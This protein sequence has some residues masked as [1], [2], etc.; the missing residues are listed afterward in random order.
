MGWKQRCLSRLL[1]PHVGLRR[2][3]ARSS[4]R[5]RFGF[6]RSRTAP[7]G[8]AFGLRTTES[9]AW[10]GGVRTSLRLSHVGRRRL[11]L[12]G[13]ACTHRM[14]VGS[15]K[16]ARSGS[17]RARL[18]EQ[19]QSELRRQS[20]DGPDPDDTGERA[21]AVFAVRFAPPALQHNAAPL[22]LSIEGRRARRLATKNT[23]KSALHT[24]YESSPLNRGSPRSVE[25][26]SA[27]SVLGTPPRDACRT[28]ARDARR[29][30]PPGAVWAEVTANTVQDRTW[31]PSA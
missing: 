21:D 16:R 22:F 28:K 29:S 18:G 13:L 3:T 19:R 10:P 7:F 31:S 27:C 24:A 8:R 12:S 9:F 17:P 26:A 2:S 20:S 11:A 6:G 4:S 30:E 23:K 5:S 25:Q 15:D 1:L 14:S